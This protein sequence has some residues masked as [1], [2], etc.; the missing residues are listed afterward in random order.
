MISFRARSHCLLGHQDDEQH[1]II[2]VLLFYLNRFI[3]YISN[4][5]ERIE[6]E[7]SEQIGAA[8]VA[9]LLG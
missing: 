4:F 8:L 1:L 9:L 3:S 6:I 5:V 2:I 7:R